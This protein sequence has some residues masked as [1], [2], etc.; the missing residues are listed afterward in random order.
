MKKGLLQDKDVLINK[1]GANTGKTGMYSDKHYQRAAINEHLFML[2]GNQSKI[3]QGYLYYTFISEEGSRQVKDRI[4]GSAQPGLNSQFTKAFKVLKPKSIFEQQKIAQVLIAVDNTIDKTK[5]LIEKNKKI[6]QG[7]MQVFF[8]GHEISDKSSKW[9]IQELCSFAFAADIDHKMPSDVEHGVPFI[10]AKDI[11]DDGEIILEGVKNISESDYTRLSRKIKPQLGDIVYSRIG[12]I[13]RV[14]LVEKQR[15]FLM[16]YSCCI[17]RM[18]NKKV[19]PE[20]L[21]WVLKS[22]ILNRQLTRET[23]SIGV[24]DLGLDKI[25]AFKIP[26]PKDEKEQIKVIELLK[27]TQKKIF[28]EQAYL[29]KLL[30]I[31]SGLMQD[32]LMGKV[33]VA[34]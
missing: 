24:P 6:K 17:I 7:L 15:K 12:T 16:S 3:T 30:K 29:S 13:G 1:D 23:Q 32:L 28:S 11:T 4:T 10:S 34:A 18:T 5:E 8:G 22:G 14:S 9:D 31:K 19:I 20:Y 21:A 2:R 33:R 27:T 25:E 26:I